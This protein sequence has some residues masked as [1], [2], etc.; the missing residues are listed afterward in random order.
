MSRRKV[1]V[2]ATCSVCGRTWTRLMSTKDQRPRRTCSLPC[3][4]QRSSETMAATNRVHA[5]ERMLA[6]N[7]MRRPEVRAQVSATLKAIG[8]QPKL[9]GGNGRGPTVPEETLATRLSRDVEGIAIGLTVPTGQRGPVPTHFK[10]D[11]SHFASRVV[12][13]VDGVSHKGRQ[14]QDRRKD[15]WLTGHGWSVLR[16]TNQQVMT[17]L[18][19]CATVALSTI[20][21]RIPG[22]TSPT[23][24]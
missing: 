6:R 1:S 21:K 5:S 18:E 11:V 12:I 13:E 23:A 10:L 4:R 2:T 14:D 16:F 17:K 9:R 19:E 20:S 7:P 8:H 22:A 24:F 3:T 15:E